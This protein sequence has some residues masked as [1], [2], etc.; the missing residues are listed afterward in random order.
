MKENFIRSKT[1]PG[2]VLNKDDKGLE[3]YKKKKTKDK[4]VQIL[5]KE[6]SEIKY[7]LS[8]ILEKMSQ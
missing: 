8:K 5:K 6:V 4:E 7:M 2:A 3:A 1:N